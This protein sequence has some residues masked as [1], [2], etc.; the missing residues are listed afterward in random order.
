M[1]LRLRIEIECD[2]VGISRAELARQVDVRPQALNDRLARGDMKASL[3]QKISIVLKVTM[4]KLMEPVTEKEYEE[5]K[6][7]AVQRSKEQVFGNT[8]AE[9]GFF[10]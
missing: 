1:S 3:L 5:A 4:E 8:G 9:A 2:R 7:T 10:K 6:S